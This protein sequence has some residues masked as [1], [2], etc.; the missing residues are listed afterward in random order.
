MGSTITPTDTEK[1]LKISQKVLKELNKNIE[2]GNK[3]IN[4]GFHVFIAILSPWRKGY[5]YVIYDLNKLDEMYDDDKE[6]NDPS[7]Y[8]NNKIQYISLREY[9]PKNI[10]RIYV[11][12]KSYN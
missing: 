9:Y 10:Y 5:D 7:I 1:S 8:N 2:L 4:L 3:F 6:K 11:K 12:V